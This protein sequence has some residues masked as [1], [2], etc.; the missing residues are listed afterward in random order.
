MS[1]M[2]W[3]QFYTSDWLAGTR[4]LSAVE[5]GIYI[6]LIATMYDTA[7]PLPNDPV[8]LARTCGASV[9]QFN[10]AIATL[11]EMG[12]IKSENNLLWNVR[13]EEE[14]KVRT[15]KTVQAK[16]AAESRWSEKDE[17]KQQNTDATASSPQCERNAI[18]KSEPE[19]NRLDSARG[20]SV[21]APKVRD[22]FVILESQMR[23]AAGWQR[24]PHPN[25]SVIGPVAVIL[26]MGVD[27]NLDLLPACRAHGPR[28]TSRTSWKYILQAA[29]SNRD[30]R[31]AASADASKPINPKQDRNHERNSKPSIID[32]FLN[33]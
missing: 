24:E 6:T 2:P 1:H 10:L 12:K 15:T 29:I 14:L 9:K 33:S 17:Q 26:T 25:L 28:L 13:V 23:E 16:R 21:A 32:Q 31:L 19:I 30:N 5:T 22:Q 27:L 11:I 18:Q 4:G 7:R 20:V 8:K 3:F